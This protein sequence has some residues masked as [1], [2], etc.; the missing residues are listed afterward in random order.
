MIADTGMR[1]PGAKYSSHT[2]F[3]QEVIVL[4]RYDTSG[5][6][7]DV[8]TAKLAQFLYHLWDKGLV[9]GSK[10]RNA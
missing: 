1:V 6:H 8:L 4:C 9:T 3:I 10:R 7:H 2:C 5:S